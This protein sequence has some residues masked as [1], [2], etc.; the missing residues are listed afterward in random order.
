MKRLLWMVMMVTVST[1]VWA[2]DPKPITDKKS[3]CETLYEFAA[4]VMLARQRHDPMPAMMDV[5]NNRG[6][7][8]AN[9]HFEAMVFEAYD[10]PAWS[11]PDSQVRSVKRFANDHYIKC[12]RTDWDTLRAKWGIGD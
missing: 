10:L 11:H 7:A 3:A 5:I 4:V 8:E 2:A 12:M 1:P 9:K 6:P